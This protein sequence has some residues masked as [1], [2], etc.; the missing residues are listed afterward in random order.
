MQLSCTLWRGA[1]DT[2]RA[3]PNEALC[4]ISRYSMWS[5]GHT[6]NLEP[7]PTLTHLFSEVGVLLVSLTAKVVGREHSATM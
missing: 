2:Y 7:L 4:E 3:L 5:A 6:C 1:E